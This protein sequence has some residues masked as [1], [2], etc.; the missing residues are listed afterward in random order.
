MCNNTEGSIGF[1]LT[2]CN[3][4]SLEGHEL[5]DDPD[6]LLD[7]PEYWVYK[8]DIANGIAAYDE[9]CISTLESG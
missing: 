4:D 5:P 8:P 3:P 2:S 6:T 1:G 7:R 9:L